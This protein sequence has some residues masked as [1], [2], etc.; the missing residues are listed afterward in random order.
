MTSCMTRPS[1]GKRGRGG[2]W[3]RERVKGG[4]GYYLLS[5]VITRC[6][7]PSPVVTTPV[8]TRCHPVSP[9]VTRRHPLSSVVRLVTRRRWHVLRVVLELP[10]FRASCLPCL[11][12]PMARLACCLGAS[13]FP[14][15][16][17]PLLGG[18]ETG[19]TG[20]HIYKHELLL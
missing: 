8:T 6:T 4:E 19:Q 5:P 10:A 1:D 14:G 12:A 13:C 15:F 20:K 7:L 3:G 11:A 16:L 18:V 17:R 2:G 9:A